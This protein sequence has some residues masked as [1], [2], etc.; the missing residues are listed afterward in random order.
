MT[1]DS[2]F[3]MGA[4]VQY[5]P[6]AFWLK[7]L[8]FQASKDLVSLHVFFL[9]HP[10]APTKWSATGLKSANMPE[11]K[12]RAGTCKSEPGFVRAREGHGQLL[13][14]LSRDKLALKIRTS[15]F[16]SPHTNV[17]VIIIGRTKASLLK[18]PQVPTAAASVLLESLKYQSNDTKTTF[19]L[20]KEERK[21]YLF[22]PNACGGLTTPIMLLKK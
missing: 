13:R 6:S 5:L 3:H 22:R 17:I 7:D 14:T 16:F 10:L 15:T 4:V 1:P 12:S 21:A 20:I 19:A 9:K 8:A 18:N 2:T 11:P